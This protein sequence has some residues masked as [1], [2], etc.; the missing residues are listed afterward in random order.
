MKKI[1]LLFGLPLVAIAVAML[2][3]H[4]SSSGSTSTTEGG[5]PGGGSCT[6]PSTCVGY[7][8]LCY[9]SVTCDNGKCAFKLQ[10]YGFV[11]PDSQQ[12]SADCQYV[13]CDGFGG[14]KAIP[15]DNDRPDAGPCKIIFC[16]EGQQHAPQPLTDGTACGPDGGMTCS[17]GECGAKTGGDH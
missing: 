17:A 12:T 6:D 14:V 15:D 3:C 7:G 4:S 9:Q 10:N 5:T 11:L 13:A 2:A 16:V 1:H 8:N